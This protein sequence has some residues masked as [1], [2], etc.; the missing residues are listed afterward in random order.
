MPSVIIP[1]HFAMK[2][3]ALFL[4]LIFLIACNGNKQHKEHQHKEHGHHHA[5]HVTA[6][7]HMHQSNFEELIERFESPERDAYQ[8]PEKVLNYLGDIKN[9]TIIDIG[10]G[11][12]YFSAK[13]AAKGAKVIAADVD[14]NFLNYIQQRIDE[15]NLSN[16]V[17]RKVPYDAPGLE[18]AEVDIAFIVNTYHH[19]ENRTAYFSKV[20][21]GTKENGELIIIDF[22]KTEIPVGPPV[23][24][25]ISIDV[26]V[27]ELKKAGYSSFDINAE[28]LPY[29]FIIKAR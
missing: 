12:G 27:D 22:F 15:N 3:I 1:K 5:E 7:E 18:E 25:K 17:L 4:P 28:L 29:Q 20:K 14:D 13:L 19:I 26:I 11:S 6:N 9:K 16:I 2:K 24:H 8:Q 10:A 23:N 21:K